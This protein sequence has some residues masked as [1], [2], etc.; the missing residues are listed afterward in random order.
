MNGKTATTGDPFRL[1]Q[2]PVPWPDVDGLAEEAITG[3]WDRAGV[4]VI[5]TA[6]LPGNFRRPVAGEWH[7]MSV[8]PIVLRNVPVLP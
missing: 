4:C 1:S 2:A 8:R 6:L 3:S 5:V 7:G